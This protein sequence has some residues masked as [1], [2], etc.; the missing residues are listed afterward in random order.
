MKRKLAQKWVAALRSGK[1]NQTTGRLKDEIGYC[2]LGV[3]CEISEARADGPGKYIENYTEVGLK[4]MTGK[5]DPYYE[6]NMD[7]LSLSKL[8]D[9]GYTFNEIADI[10]QIEYV[11]G[12]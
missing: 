1:Y 8:N 3:L 5:L 11:E 7:T 4:S 9:E 12:L 10:I 2:C 6:P